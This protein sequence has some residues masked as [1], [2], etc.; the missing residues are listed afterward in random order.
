[1]LKGG[2]LVLAFIKL[3]MVRTLSYVLGA[4]MTIAG[5]LGFAMGG[6]V[7]GIFMA[8]TSLSAV[9]LIGGLITLA[10]AVWAPMQS[11][12]WAKIAGV[13]LAIVAVLGFVMSGSVLGVLDNTM[14]NNVLHAVLAILFLWA[15][16]MPARSMDSM[17]S[18]MSSSGPAM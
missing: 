11:V 13:I 15:G 12:L 5:I 18:N 14:A 1:M 4:V 17:N 8:D 2:L 3:F 9:W 6:S 16:F 7:L 10:V